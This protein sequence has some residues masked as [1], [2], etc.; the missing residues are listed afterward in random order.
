MTFELQV[1]DRLRTV[2]IRRRAH[3]F[4][5]SV[6]GRARI[7]DAAH[8]GLSSWS[9]LVSDVKGAGSRSVEAIV[10]P[11]RGNSGYDV[12]IDGVTIPVHLRGGLGRHSRDRHA[13]GATGAGPQ[14]LTAPM[15]GKVVRVLVQ[16]GAEVKAKQGL[17]VVE[18]MKM[19][20]ELRAAKAGRVRE[21]L[22][23]EGQS[24]EAGAP[25]IEIE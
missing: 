6:D 2:E 8:V 13:H 5:I 20:N 16:P 25:L 15:A 10:E 21:V 24:V 1:G 14:R 12:R 11:H 9:L 17:I 23:T 19:E 18:A 3:G 4:E 22:V 7:V